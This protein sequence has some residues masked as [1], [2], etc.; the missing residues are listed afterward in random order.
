MQ[1]R[2]NILE[3]FV[4]DDDLSLLKLLSD[5]S[6]RDYEDFG[7]ERGGGGQDGWM[8][9]WVCILAALTVDFCHMFLAGKG[10][11]EVSASPKTPSALLEGDQ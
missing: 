6:V 5:W 10:L 3:L 4:T 11:T 1:D 2:A 7:A 9:W 8:L